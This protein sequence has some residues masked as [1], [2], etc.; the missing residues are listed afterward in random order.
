MNLWQM[1]SDP[2]VFIRAVNKI[3]LINTSYI[4]NQLMVDALELEQ[5][6]QKIKNQELENAKIIES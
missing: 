4:L 1:L 2:A 6:S 3:F 5:T